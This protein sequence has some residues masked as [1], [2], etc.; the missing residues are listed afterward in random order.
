LSAAG[1]QGRGPARSAA[2]HLLS[3]EVARPT[4][5]FS[6]NERLQRPIDGTGQ[7]FSRR[8]AHDTLNNPVNRRAV[9]KIAAHKSRV[10]GLSG[11]E[12]HFQIDPLF[13]VKSFVEGD[14]K[15]Q[16]ANIGRLNS[17][18]NFFERRLR[19]QICVAK[20]NRQKR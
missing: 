18:P 3:L 8:T 15:R 4:N 11:H 20:N 12:N 10:H 6:A 19:V 14:M 17:H 9:I 7:D 16:E 13:A 1:H 5:I 2:G